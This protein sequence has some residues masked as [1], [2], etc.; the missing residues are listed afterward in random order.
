M[1]GAG[2]AGVY[3]CEGQSGHG[4][5]P[6]E[7]GHLG[8]VVGEDLHHASLDLG[9]VGVM[10]SRLHSVIFRY[11]DEAS[12]VHFLLYLVIVS[13]QAVAIQGFRGAGGAG[14]YTHGLLQ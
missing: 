4:E 11:Y 6:P 2:R 5:V 12:S 3:L 9:G 14:G 10:L 1:E 7:G 13:H 8:P